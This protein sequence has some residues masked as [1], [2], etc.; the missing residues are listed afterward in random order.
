M[1]LKYRASTFYT[2][3]DTASFEAHAYFTTDADGVF[4]G[5]APDGTEQLRFTLT[6]TNGT[7]TLC[8]DGCSELTRT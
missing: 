8:D 2:N 5:V 7:L 1:V 3:E 6:L 4:H